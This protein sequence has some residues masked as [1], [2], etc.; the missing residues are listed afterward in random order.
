MDKI[1]RMAFVD[2][3]W[4]YDN[5]LIGVEPIPIIRDDAAQP[6]QMTVEEARW[7]LRRYLPSLGGT[8]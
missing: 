3:Y 6:R 5:R 4:F 1:E 2:R 8:K 7:F